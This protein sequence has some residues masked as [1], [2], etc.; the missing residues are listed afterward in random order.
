MLGNNDGEPTFPLHFSLVREHQQSDTSLLEAKT[1]PSTTLQ[2]QD[3]RGTKMIVGKSGE[4]VMP[5]TLQQQVLEFYHESLGHPGQTR[6]ELSIKQHF[7]WKNMTRDVKK[8]NLLHMLDEEEACNKAC[9][10]LPAKELTDDD[11]KPWNT[12]CVDVVGPYEIEAK[13]MRSH[14]RRS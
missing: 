8:H 5:V 1:A 6:T 2:E 14:S 12:V 7:V 3:F 11:I 4:I 10:Q 9:G 13:V